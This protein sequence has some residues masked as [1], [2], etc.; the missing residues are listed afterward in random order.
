MLKSNSQSLQDIFA[1][2]IC[3]QDSTYIEIGAN[4]PKKNSNSYI[5]ET[6]YNWKG[7]SLELD[8]TF[9]NW[10]KDCPERKNKIYWDNALTFDYRKALEENKLPNEIGYLSCD[11]EPPYNTFSALQTVINQGIS[12]KCITFEHDLYQYTEKD[13]NQISKEYLC[14]CGYKVAV[15]DV[16][17]K[18]PS[19]HF[20]TWFVR[21]DINFE[22]TTF[23]K[24]KNQ[25]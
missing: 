3:G 23:E 16:Y 10:W 17:W 11:I 6:L 7:F 9:E 20:E 24:W 12:F 19:N 5:L 4:R 14:S 18:R 21:E 1:L 8:S 15:T 2:S 22:S 25:L 13:F